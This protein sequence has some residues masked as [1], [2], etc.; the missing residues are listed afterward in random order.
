MGI[1]WGYALLTL[2][3]ALAVATPTAHAGA[4]DDI[5]AKSKEAM[6]NYDLMD[7]G[8]AKKLLNQAIV[9]AKKAK[10]DKEPTT[11]KLY[12]RLGI[13]VFADGDQDGARVAFLSAVEIDPKIQIE[14]AYKS[15]EL[16]KLLDQARA[17]FSSGGEEPVDPVMP[18]G[19]DCSGVK[20]IE[21][22]ILD[23][24]TR[25]KS[26][27]IELLLGA[28]VKSPAKVVVGFR[29]EGEAEFT[30]QKLTKDGD[31]KYTGT[32]PASAT[33]GEILHYY[34]AALNGN[35][36]PIVGKGSSGSPNIIELAMGADVGPSPG[37]V[38]DPIGSDPVPTST[39][40]AEVSGGV[41]RGG[42]APKVYL[43]VAGGTGF[44]YVTGRTEG[45]STVQNCCIG[46]SLVV[47]TPE[48]GFYVSPKVSIGIAGRIGL[49]LGANTE[50]HATAAPGGLLRIRY[51]LGAD[52]QG[53][54]VMGQVGAGF[55]RNTIKL[56]NGTNGMDT[57]IVAQGPLLVG[58][59]LGYMKRLGGSVAFLFDFSVLAGIAVT[60]R[61]GMSV[62][63]SGVGADA[64]I[65]LAVGF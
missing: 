15:P 7:Y 34:V 11:A 32:I 25:G 43:A 19:P 24:G 64:S 20:G 48:L 28:D 46:N 13:V 4:K 21:H 9:A 61:I 55:M 58:A 30:E 63:N 38:E 33:K 18:E 14:A 51:A 39:N 10:L 53:I 44:G 29:A 59:G 5:A 36:K 60:D 16:T 8:V 6:E 45:G 50:G 35:G 22:T 56:D 42:K 27:A 41:V 37:D 1:R 40:E 26:V 57:D 49:P 31:C 17:E 2:V 23:A 52:G 65:G 12:L 3:L 62:L 47:I 54:R